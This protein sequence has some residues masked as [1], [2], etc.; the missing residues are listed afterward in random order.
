MKRF[1]TLAKLCTC[2]MHLWSHP[3]FVAL[4]IVLLAPHRS[5]RVAKD[6]TF[7]SDRI[8]EMHLVP[9]SATCTFG[10]SECDI[11]LHLRTLRETLRWYASKMRKG[12]GALVRSKENGTK[13]VVWLE[14]LQRCIPEWDQR[15][16]VDQRFR[17]SVILALFS[18]PPLLPL[19]SFETLGHSVERK[20]IGTNVVSW[21]YW[22]SGR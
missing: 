19:R 21:G 22:G 15:S 5:S 16:G 11:P 13:K 8:F 6:G 18:V 14:V 9:S 4:C 2:T 17:G 12:P 3:S 10:A 7:T 1:I 20:C